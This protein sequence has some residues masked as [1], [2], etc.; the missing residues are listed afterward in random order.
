MVIMDEFNNALIIQYF[1][2]DRCF[3]KYARRYTL[4]HEEKN[5]SSKCSQE[6]NSINNFC[7]KQKVKKGFPRVLL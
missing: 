2:M 4:T 1:T 6:S 7:K 3:Y 5:G